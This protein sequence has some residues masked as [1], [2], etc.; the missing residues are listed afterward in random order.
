[1]GLKRFPEFIAF[2]GNLADL[3]RSQNLDTKAKEYLDKGL[4]ITPANGTLH[5]ALGLWYIRN[6]NES[7][8]L[9][10]LKKAASLEPSNPSYL[11]GYAIGLVSIHETQKAIQLLDGYITKHGNDPL[12]LNGLISIYQDIKQDDKVGYYANIRKNIFGY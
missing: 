7:E 9:N 5:Y 12:I 11:Y 10:E 3:Y 2:Y 8:G 4:T 6:H 1:M